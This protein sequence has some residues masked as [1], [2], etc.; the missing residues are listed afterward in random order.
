MAKSV[1]NINT[2]NNAS[3]YLISIGALN[4]LLVELAE[5]DIVEKLTTA[6]NVPTA[7]TLIYGIIGV[8]GAWVGIQALMGNV[9]ITK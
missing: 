1:M 4:W 7:A 3:I 6:I 5:F 9:K 8:A 2:I